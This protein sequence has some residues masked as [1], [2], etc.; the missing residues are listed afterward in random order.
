MIRIILY[1]FF[2]TI[3]LYHFVHKLELFNSSNNNDINISPTD[4]I[5]L[6]IPILG[7]KLFEDVIKYINDD[8]DSNPNGLTGVT[9][10]INK[11]KGNCLEF[12]I[13]GNAMCFPKN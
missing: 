9:K 13:T 7:D 3:I 12:G 11:C 2:I 5:N 1:A 10:C 4:A 8:I 6:N